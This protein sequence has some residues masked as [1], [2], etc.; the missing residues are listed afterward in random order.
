MAD[1]GHEETDRIL[2]ALE[3]KLKT[4]YS[5]A[6]ANAEKRFTDYMAAFDRKD[7]RH[8]KDVSTG[9]WTQEY[10]DTWRKNQLL[11]ADTIT[12]IRDTL[13]SD[14]HNTNT[15]AI[16]L[17]RDK[18]V[19]IYA[20]NH[21]YG[22]Y[23]IEHGL[24]V[25]TSYSLY[26]HSTVER[27]MKEDPELLPR[28]SKK[29][30]KEIDAS[31]L[32]W[33]KEKLTSAFTASILSGDSIPRMASRISEV[34]A[35]DRNAA[36][37]NARTMCTGA[38]NG[39]RMN[40]Y[41]RAQKMGIDVKQEWEAT[42]DGRTRHSHRSLDGEIIK[43]GQKFSNGCRF[44]G[45]PEGP[46]WEVYNCRCT[47][48]AVV[49]GIDPAVFDKSD[50]LQ[51]K[52]GNMS[53]TYERWKENHVRQK[54][55]AVDFL[56][57]RKEGSSAAGQFEAYKVA[58]E[59]YRDIP[60][61]AQLG[62]GEFTVESGYPNSSCLI[63]SKTIRMGTNP[64][65]EEFYHEFGHLAEEYVLDKQDVDEYKR[66]LTEGLG[67]NDIVPKTFVDND[68]NDVVVWAL[69]GDRFESSYQSRLYVK[70]IQ[71]ALNADGT[72]NTDCMLE[73]VSE[74]FRKMLNGEKISSEAKKLLKGLK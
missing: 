10:Y 15:V 58:A 11:Y 63:K 48:I 4:T 67:V 54:Q 2:K 60:L 23:E 19:D 68:G 18:Q 8:K 37:R 1:Y 34:A 52:L 49:N 42:L 6:V 57:K 31:D 33:H 32:K 71:N 35:M 28:P 17:V 45:D 66:Y 36:I 46:A 51:R 24:G 70:N 16:D 39:G 72:I 62:V 41:Q 74:V 30:Q 73:C 55:V 69:K 20:L 3:K 26:D 59:A 12:E 13:A 40:S 9:K 65:K 47:I 61:K 22:T 43:V 38:E 21:N 5:K 50:T 56:M 44:P 64:E 29:R 25:D 7:A 27:L 14:L 53:I